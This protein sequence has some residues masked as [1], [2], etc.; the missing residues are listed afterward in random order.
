MK[1][2]ATIRKERGLTLEDMAQHLNVG[3][4]TYFQYENSDRSIPAE[5]AI[6]IANLLKVDVGEIFLPVRFTASKIKKEA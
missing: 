6:G 5:V 4:N 3:V 1:S 2:L